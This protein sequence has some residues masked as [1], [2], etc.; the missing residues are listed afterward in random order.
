[1]GNGLQGPL[2]KIK[3]GIHFFLNR[4]IHVYTDKKTNIIIFKGFRAETRNQHMGYL[5]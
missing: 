5:N 1:M 4:C 3:S 2:A